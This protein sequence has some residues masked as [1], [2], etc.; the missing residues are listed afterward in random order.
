MSA[1]MPLR[2]RL[3]ALPLLRP[4][5]LPRSVRRACCIVC[6][7]HIDLVPQL[8]AAHPGL[9][10]PLLVVPDLPRGAPR[11]LALPGRPEISLAGPERLG[12]TPEWPK[13][14][15]APEPVLLT[16]L[17]RFMAVYGGGMLYLEGGSGPPF[18]L[19]EPRPDFFSN[20]AAKLEEVY[21][22][23]ADEASRITYAARIKALLTG[24]AGY[25]PVAAHGEYEHPR[26]APAPGDIMIDGGVSD[27]VDAQIAFARSVGPEGQVHGF[28]P[29]PWMADA[30]RQALA[31]WPW[32]RLHSAG[33][34]ERRGQAA[35]A[36]LR[37]SSHIC[38]DGTPDGGPDGAPEGATVRC[39]LV[40]I[41]EVVREEG[42][43]RV[44]CIKL[45]VEGAELDALRGAEETIR[46]F[47]PKLVICLYHRPEDL[48]TLPLF[49]K[50]LVPEYRLEVAH[51]SYGFTDTILY[52]EAPGT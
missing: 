24:D 15:L 23:L 33:L 39:E 26:V 19:R 47:R 21:G 14:F 43:E 18:G 30:A 16:A 27:M 20:N 10:I 9:A 35:F 3:N 22:L 29:I 4:W 52:A 46:R 48:M 31:P 5:G 40:T 50:S 2:E 42:L 28:E 51:A 13:V 38:A 37:D 34:A 1:A 44:D 32:Y 25:L 45:D 11:R 6:R 8:C 41:D 12:A 17:C 49:V 36:S 7:E